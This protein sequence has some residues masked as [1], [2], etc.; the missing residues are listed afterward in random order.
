MRE[1]LCQIAQNARTDLTNEVQP[2]DDFERQVVAA[3]GEI[4]WDEAITAI[5]GHRSGNCSC[6]DCKRAKNKAAGCDCN[7]DTDVHLLWCSMFA[8]PESE[9]ANHG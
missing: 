4:S 2:R 9:E 8:S 7:S 6:W 3:L 5:R 1:T